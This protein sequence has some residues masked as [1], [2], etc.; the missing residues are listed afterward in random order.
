[1]DDSK[2]FMFPG[3]GNPGTGSNGLDPNLMIKCLHNTILK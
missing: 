3:M 2:V 1:M